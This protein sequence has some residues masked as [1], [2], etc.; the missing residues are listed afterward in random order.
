MIASKTNLLEKYKEYLDFDRTLRKLAIA[1][2]H[3]SYDDYMWHYILIYKDI[4]I[5]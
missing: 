1:H 3:E 5:I 2:F 4:I